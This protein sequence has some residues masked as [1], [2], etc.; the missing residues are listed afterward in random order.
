[1]PNWNQT[2]V[3]PVTPGSSISSVGGDTPRPTYTYKS[4]VAP[5]AGSPA[6][7][8][9][10]A[11]MRT[12]T[13]KPAYVEGRGFDSQK[14]APTSFNQS[15]VK[16]DPSKD[17]AGIGMSPET[18]AYGASLNRPRSIRSATFADGGM[19]SPV[20]DTA[21][22]QARERQLL[23]GLP[24]RT[25]DW[26]RKLEISNALVGAPGNSYMDSKMTRSQREAAM[27]Q[28][29]GVAQQLRDQYSHEDDRYTNAYLDATGRQDTGYQN[30]LTRRNLLQQ[31][32]VRNQGALELQGLQNEGQLGVTAQQGRNAYNVA[33]LQGRDA[34]NRQGLMEAGATERERIGQTASIRQANALYAPGGLLE[35]EMKM[36]EGDNAL[37]SRKLSD[38]LNKQQESDSLSRVS[39]LF[40]GDQ[41]MAKQA[42]DLLSPEQRVLVGPDLLGAV[43][44]VA[45]A[46]MKGRYESGAKQWVPG[47][48]DATRPGTLDVGQKANGVY[49][50]YTDLNMFTDAGAGDLRYDDP[51]SG[52]SVSVRRESV[53]PQLYKRLSQGVQ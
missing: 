11:P 32:G 49:P 43:S 52:S 48:G 23:A 29:Y 50:W 31:A 19:G 9:V 20:S 21:R 45:P 14:P 22:Y 38:A 40:N 41:D 7:P 8:K 2:G 27:A 34:Y 47:I 51:R 26:E 33:D 13:E 1:M 42:L 12:Y 16:L 3:R 25:S 30:D 24:A 46:V 17:S 5:Q 18:S 44:R 6:A 4:P 28:T 36:K 35:R 37:S 10:N 39:E 53:S 15:N